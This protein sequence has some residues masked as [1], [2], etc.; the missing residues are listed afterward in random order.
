MYA[1]CGRNVCS[2][3]VNLIVKN[4]VQPKRR[5]RVEV[6]HGLR[7]KM[8]AEL[9]YHE[10]LNSLI[11]NLIFFEVWIHWQNHSFDCRGDFH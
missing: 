5:R 11:I 9:A 1:H 8:D 10:L 4:V 6:V 2:G 3:L 7:G